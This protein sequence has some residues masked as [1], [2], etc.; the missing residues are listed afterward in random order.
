[1]TRVL[2][3]RPGTT[4]ERLRGEWALFPPYSQ[5]RQIGLRAGEQ[6]NGGSRPGQPQ[7]HPLQPCRVL[8]CAHTLIVDTAGKFSA[9][10]CVLVHSQQQSA[11]SLSVAPK[12]VLS[13][14]PCSV[15]AVTHV[16]GLLVLV[17]SV[18]HNG[19]WQEYA[20]DRQSSACSLPGLLH[21][22]NDSVSPILSG[23]D[24]GDSTT[25]SCFP[26][27]RAVADHTAEPLFRVL[28]AVA[29]TEG[30]TSATWR[31]PSHV[32]SPP[33]TPSML[34]ASVI[35]RR[36]N[37]CQALD[38]VARKIYTADLYLPLYGSIG[39]HTYVSSHMRTHGRAQAHSRALLT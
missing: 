14:M 24:T 12:A 13:S 26:Q 19:W 39:M 10:I 30:G 31:R 35:L 16:L 36:R 28:T 37:Q 4:L 32:L 38:A 5:Q 34:S 21:T 17:S 11:F 7:R 8:F 22:D 1:M 33:R 6:R 29:P 3:A 9:Y 27:E 25:F 15:S 23:S 20:A 18:L 2:S